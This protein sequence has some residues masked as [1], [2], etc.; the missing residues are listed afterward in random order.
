MLSPR[1]KGTRE[2]LEALFIAVQKLSFNEQV[3]SNF[4]NLFGKDI[5]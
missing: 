2:K 5:T 4:L 3:K 1:E